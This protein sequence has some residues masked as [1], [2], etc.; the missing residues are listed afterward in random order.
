MTFEQPACQKCE[1]PLISRLFC[2][3]CNAFQTVPPE[4]DYFGVLGFPVS[5]EINSE[6]L[7]ERYKRLSLVLHPDFF[8]AAPEEEKR[9]SEKASAMLNTAYSTLRESTSRA[10]Y[11]LFLFTKEKNLNERTLPDGFLQEMFFLQESLDELLES[12]D[13]SALNKM[14]EDLRTRHKE[15]ESYYAPL[16][17][18]F[19]DLPEDSEILQQLQTHLNAER[20][21]RRLLDRIPA[22]D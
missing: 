17:K 8:A 16:F 6:D 11:L 18:N 3:S 20:Y 5:F 10:G 9:L 1:S 15:I 21:L 13:S 14:N 4:I 7:E 2:L 22:T 12:S 19:K